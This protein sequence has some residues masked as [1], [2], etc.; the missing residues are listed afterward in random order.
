MA[1]V[2]PEPPAPSLYAAVRSL[3][4]RPDGVAFGPSELTDLR[5]VR[6]SAK[7]RITPGRAAAQDGATV[8]AAAWAG[9]AVAV[10]VAAATASAA[11]AG[12]IRRFISKGSST[13]PG[14]ADDNDVNQWEVQPTIVFPNCYPG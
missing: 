10:R 9:S 1:T 2:A 5:S 12:P 13:F 4:P 8:T 7:Q 11:S 3:G 6:R 14:D